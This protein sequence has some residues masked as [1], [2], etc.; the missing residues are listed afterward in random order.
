VADDS[1]LVLILAGLGLLA[2]C[3]PG[4][5]VGQ[6][7]SR[8]RPIGYL[9]SVRTATFDAFRDG[10]G[11]LGYVEGQ[12]IAI[13]YRDAE[14]DVERLPAL[15]ADLVRLPVEVIVSHNVRALVAAGRAA[16]RSVHSGALSTSAPR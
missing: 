16:E 14:G 6:A 13:E 4:S 7:P 1:V 10:L 11:D 2:G 9:A 3:G 8:P 5:V 12:N 15:A